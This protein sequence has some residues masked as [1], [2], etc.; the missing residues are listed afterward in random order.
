MPDVPTEAE[1]KRYLILACLVAGLLAAAGVSPAAPSETT[2]SAARPAAMPPALVKASTPPVID[3]IL[4]DPAWAA[5]QKYDGFKTF[6]PDYGK[7]ASQKT[8]AFIAYDSENFYFA[9]RCYDSEPAKIK[10]AMSKRDN[11]FQDDVVFI[12]L[13]TFDDAQSGYSFILNPL[14][15]QGDGMVDVNGN[16]STSFDAVWYSKGRIDDQGWTVEARVPLQ[17]IRFPGKKDLTW[18]ILFIRF[19]TRTSEQVSFP[20]IDPNYGSLMG[21]AQSFGVSGLRH[22]R[23]AELIPAATTTVDYG[24]SRATWSRPGARRSARSPA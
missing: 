11:I 2:G 6:K 24:Q 4:D 1:L 7:E 8:E 3:G 21:Q 13:D 12:V 10:A 9:F 19:F 15:I 23:V 14:G 20:P 18:R 22:K 16:L 5:G 17:S